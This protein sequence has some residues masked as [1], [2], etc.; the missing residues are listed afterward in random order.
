MDTEGTQISRQKLYE[1]VWAQPVTKLAKQFG[2]SDV[3]FAKICKKYNIPRPPRGYWARRQAGEKAKRTPLPSGKDELITINPNRYNT[4]S[5]EDVSMTEISFESAEANRIVVRNTLRRPHPLV[6]QA[7]EFL[8]SCEPNQMGILEVPKGKY[9][10]IQVSKKTRSRALRIMDALLKGLEKRGYV[11][12]LSEQGA[13]IK[14]LGVDIC[15]GISEELETRRTEPKNHDLGGYYRFGHSRFDTTRVP[16]GK[17]CLAIDGWGHS[18]SGRKK[19]RDSKTK[20]LEDSL[21]AFIVGMLRMATWEKKHMEEM[22]EKERQR[23]EWLR[24]R[25]EEK[26]LRAEKRRRIEEEQ[27]RVLAL[28]S[29]A[30]NWRKSQLIREYIAEVERQIN[31]DTCT[32]QTDANFED[33]LLWAKQQADRLDPLTSSPKSILD[34][35]IEDEKHY[36]HRNSVR[37]F[38]DY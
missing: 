6:E 29:D 4:G 19:W 10:D 28:V 3:G 12:D 32:L 37:S 22:R 9:P 8:K 24:Q 35:P 31:A 17:L 18:Y 38:Y 25:E 26:R 2:L 11:T 16:S 23:Q 14:M 15:F 5:I 13:R 20:Q 36:D 7:S 30:E 27:A 33:W 1:E 34:E 21:N